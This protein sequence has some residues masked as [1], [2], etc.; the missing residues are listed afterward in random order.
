MKLK[1]IFLITLLFS[2]SVSATTHVK[3]LRVWTSPE[4]T[5]AVIDLSGQ[6]DYKLFQLENPPRVVV[7][8]E[9]TRV[10]KKSALKV[11]QLYEK[12]ATAEKVKAPC[13]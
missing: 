5:K 7:D 2:F 1:I 9:N 6:V 12:F 4:D 13:D 11:T 10:T 8:L 3:G